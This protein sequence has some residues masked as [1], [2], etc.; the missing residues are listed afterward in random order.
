VTLL[1]SPL[2]ATRNDCLAAPSRLAPHWWS[3]HL[4]GRLAPPP[5]G[6]LQD[7]APVITPTVG[8]APPSTGQAGRTTPVH[9][10]GRPC[11]MS[12]HPPAAP[13]PA[14]SAAAS[15]TSP[16][17]P[18]TPPAARS[19]PERWPRPASAVAPPTGPRDAAVPAAVHCPAPRPAC[20]AAQTIRDLVTESSMTV[21]PRVGRTGR[22]LAAVLV[23]GVQQRPGPRPADAVAALDRLSFLADFRSGGEPGEAGRSG[24]GPPPC[25]TGPPRSLPSAAGAVVAVLPRKHRPG[26]ARPAALKRR[27][28]A[29][30]CGAVGGA[31]APRRPALAAVRAAVRPFTLLPADLDRACRGTLSGAV[32]VLILR[33]S[34]SRR[35]AGGRPA[36]RASTPT[37]SQ[38]PG[39]GGTRY[40]TSKD[41]TECTPHGPRREYTGAK[42]G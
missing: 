21:T 22:E 7:Q 27:R 2:C 39:S 17:S 34:T 28:P 24:V 9:A 25:V 37:P 23:V 16:P 20:P 29:V 35:S 11:A 5:R 15:A 13:A 26:V 38:T 18:P 8:S 10:P 19:W 32:I 31:A 40:T 41:A 12:A 36:M 33:D 6:V 4:R 1:P 3:P 30:R 14:R 42:Q